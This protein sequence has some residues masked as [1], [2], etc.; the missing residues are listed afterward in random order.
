MI[1]FGF[2]VLAFLAVVF[3]FGGLYGL[4]FG[5]VLVAGT[6]FTRVEAR[7]L[8]GLAVLLMVLAPFALLAQGLP[9]GPIVGPGFGTDHLLA[10][11]F[12]GMSLATAGWAGLLEL[13]LGS[14]R[15]RVAEPG[16]GDTSSGVLHP[17]ND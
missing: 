2:V 10:H 12:V 11:V 13:A 6:V 3:L 14:L 17:P 9:S 16:P 7:W 4:L 8:W 15:R 5:V 1:R